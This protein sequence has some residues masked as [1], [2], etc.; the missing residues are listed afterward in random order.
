MLLKADKVL[1]LLFEAKH[2][3]LAQIILQ[4]QRRTESFFYFAFAG[5]V[6]RTDN[7]IVFRLH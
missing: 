3:K 5:A 7:N 6:N 1:Y 4:C 2:G